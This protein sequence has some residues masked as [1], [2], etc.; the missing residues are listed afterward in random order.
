MLLSPISHGAE[1]RS[2][3]IP[4]RN[5]DAMSGAKR[6]GSNDSHRA[7]IETANLIVEMDRECE[8]DQ[9]SRSAWHPHE[10]SSFLKQIRAP[11]FSSR[12]SSSNGI[13]A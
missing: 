11:I 5:Q 12:P 3:T 8:R 1:P 4:H 2:H 10:H 13:L 9:G 6:F 7:V